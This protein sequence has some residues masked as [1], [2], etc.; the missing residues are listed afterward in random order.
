MTNL[1]LIGFTSSGKSA[2]GSALAEKL[3][4]EI[5]DLDQQIEAL[6]A[7]EFSEHKSCREIYR[8]WGEEKF[9]ALESQALTAL[10]EKENIILATGGGVLEEERNASR[11]KQ[12]GSCIYLQ[13]G[14]ATIF[15]RMSG[16]KGFP[17]F[18]QSNPTVEGIEEKL[19]Q[20][21][22]AYHQ[23]ADITILVDNKNIENIV[24][25][26]LALIEEK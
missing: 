4:C 7:E 19:Q 23:L 16:A 20:R 21:R 10:A 5:I 25:E 6:A 11:L 17:A 3:D 13:A 18:L 2:V 24:N 14:A 9:R 1:V 22:Q 26:I 8:E 12:I 15:Q